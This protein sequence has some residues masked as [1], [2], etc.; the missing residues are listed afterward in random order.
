MA[1]LLAATYP[2]IL[3]R[4]FG[5]FEIRPGLDSERRERYA[6][7]SS[8][9]SRYCSYLQASLRN[10]DRLAPILPELR[11]F[12]RMS[13]PGKIRRIHHLVYLGSSV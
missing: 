1:L 5:D 10:G 12:Y 6:A 8:L 7:A 11:R 9:A 4:M 13:Q 3:D 2:D